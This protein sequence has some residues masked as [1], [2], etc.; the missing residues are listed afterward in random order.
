MADFSDCTFKIDPRKLTIKQFNHKFVL[1]EQ[2]M[3]QQFIRQS[4]VSPIQKMQ[5]KET[6]ENV[7][8]LFNHIMSSLDKLKHTLYTV[9][10]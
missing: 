2:I 10:R 7:N 6:N 1:N 4:N 3:K 8:K 9:K 5:Q